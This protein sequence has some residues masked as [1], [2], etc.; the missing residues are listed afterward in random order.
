MWRE[1]NIVRAC[2]ETKIYNNICFFCD[3]QAAVVVYLEEKHRSHAVG[4]GQD[5]ELLGKML[6]ECD[7]CVDA[8]GDNAKV[9]GL[10][11]YK[12]SIAPTQPGTGETT[13]CSTGFWQW[14]SRGGNRKS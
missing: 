13:S 7:G 2:V 14:T 11:W 3:V 5:S 10:W 8:C 4:Y 12:R 1:T 6:L 9:D